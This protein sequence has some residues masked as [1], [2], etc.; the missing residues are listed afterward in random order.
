MILK[1]RFTFQSSQHSRLRPELYY[2]HSFENTKATDFNRL[3]MVHR[4]G[5]IIFFISSKF[6][7]MVKNIVLIVN[8][9][10]LL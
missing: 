10:M 3:Y 8:A 2:D 5:D 1:N 7:A 4:I 6:S 9:Y